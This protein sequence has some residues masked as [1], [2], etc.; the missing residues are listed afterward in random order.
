MK[1]KS[2]NIMQKYT[3]IQAKKLL[4]SGKEVI[5]CASKI[6]PFSQL[7]YKVTLQGDETF[8]TFYNSFKYYNCTKDTGKSICFYGTHFVPTKK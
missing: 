1:H 6:S 2:F 5:V 3:K 7:A 4:E 8:D